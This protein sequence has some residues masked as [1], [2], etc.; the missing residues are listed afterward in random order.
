MLEKQYHIGATPQVYCILCHACFAFMTTKCSVPLLRA[1]LYGVSSREWPAL[2]SIPA[3][4]VGAHQLKNLGNFF[5]AQQIQELT[6]CW[7]V[8]K[9]ILLIQM[10]NQNSLQMTAL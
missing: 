10:H 1:K 2:D 5:R 8:L 7:S 4:T 6:P 9:N 3:E